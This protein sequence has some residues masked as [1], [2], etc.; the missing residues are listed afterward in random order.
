MYSQRYG[1]Y[2]TKKQGKNDSKFEAGYAQELAI[3]K[4]AK[5]IKDYQEQ[6]NIPLIVNGY[7]VCTYRIDFKIFHNDGTIEFLETKGLA[8]PVWKLKWKLF[9]ALFGDLP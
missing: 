4:K 6:V 1:Y 9:E 7:L 2:H 5:D 3:R 8:M